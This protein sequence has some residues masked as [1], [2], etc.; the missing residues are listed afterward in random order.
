MLITEQKPLVKLVY[1]L[2]GTL[3]ILGLLSATTNLQY[4]I[5]VA[6]ILIFT[7]GLVTPIWKKRILIKR[8]SNE[9]KSIVQTNKLKI[10]RK[11]SMRD[12]LLAEL[13]KAIRAQVKKAT[14]PQLFQQIEEKKKKDGNTDDAIKELSESL[15]RLLM[16][17]LE[18]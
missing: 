15:R 9:M 14:H 1:L 13:E 6:V 16:E 5:S 3:L 10:L 8:T 4:L 17:D 7:V 18:K 12:L 2:F 11:K